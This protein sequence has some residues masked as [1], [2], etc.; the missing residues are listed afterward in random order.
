MKCVLLLKDIQ[1]QFCLLSINKHAANIWNTSVNIRPNNQ[2]QE[3][4]GWKSLHRLKGK[5]VRFV[6]EKADSKYLVKVEYS[7]GIQRQRHYNSNQSTQDHMGWNIPMFL[8]PFNE[9]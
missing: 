6:S 2:P 8:V 3:S 5:Y 9:L 4:V 1:M 7:A